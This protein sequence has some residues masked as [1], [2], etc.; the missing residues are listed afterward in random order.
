MRSDLAPLTQTPLPDSFDRTA[1]W[2]R[3]VPPRP[4]RTP[5]VAAL[6]LLLSV[7][8][9]CSWPV[10]VEHRAG[11]VIE[12]RSTSPASLHHP[13]VQA[14]D[15]LVPAERRHLVELEPT[16]P[17]GGAVVR[18]AVLGDAPGVA[19]AWRRAALEVTGARSARVLPLDVPARERL[20]LVAARRLLGVSASPEVSDAQ[21]Q[22]ALDRAFTGREALAPQ[23]GRAPDGSRVLHVAGRVQLRLQPGMRVAPLPGLDGALVITTDARPDLDALQVDGRAARSLSTDSSSLAL[24]DLPPPIR[25]AVRE[26]IGA[27]SLAHVRTI[28]LY[29][30]SL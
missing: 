19:E 28:R 5:P 1:R 24:D 22:R 29:P 2:L 10:E 14:L 20:G 26:L 9:A 12:V 21:M 30:D 25:D 15:R 13:V 6:V 23:V 4:S 16:G 8:G 27:D 18:Y 7:V 11:H 3:S 17:G